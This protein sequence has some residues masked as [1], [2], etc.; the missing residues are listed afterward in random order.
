MEDLEALNKD[1]ETLLQ[2]K[3][4][5]EEKFKMVIYNIYAYLHI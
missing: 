2:E 3:I 1:K 4:N 5:A